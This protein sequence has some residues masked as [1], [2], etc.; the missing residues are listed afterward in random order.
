MRAGAS[1]TRLLKVGATTAVM[2]FFVWQFA[3]TVVT[4]HQGEL[5][6]RLAVQVATLDDWEVKVPLRQMAQLGE[7]A[8]EP[9][10]AVAASRRA[11]GSAIA[12]QIVD[13]KLAVWQLLAKESPTNPLGSAPSFLTAALAKHIDE[14]GPA[15][16]QWAEH[17]ALELIDLAD[18]MPAEQVGLLLADCT[19]ILVAVPPRGPKM[20]TV[21]GAVGPTKTVPGLDAPQP[22]L[23]TLAQASEM[24]WRAKV[25][26]R[27]KRAL[28]FRGQTGLVST[29]SPSLSP[30]LKG[31]APAPTT[32][33]WSAD[34][35]SQEKHLGTLVPSSVG[36]SL[37]GGRQLLQTS[38]SKVVDVPNPQAM[39]NLAS[40]LRRLSS[41]VLLQR[42]HRSD[43]YEAGIIRV[44]LRER[45]F[46]N[47][48]L[49][50]I[51][52]LASPNVVD[53]LRIFEVIS[54]LPAASGRRLL[55]GLLKDQDADVRLRALTA[56]ATTN[57][58]GLGDLARELAVGDEDLRVSELASRILRQ[59]R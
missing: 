16:K 47:G 41:E 36:A 20:R 12:R 13:E 31:A 43:F 18:A 17:L 39:Q 10:V 50:L 32:L 52:Q 42:L 23:E 7:P 26:S 49:L 34:S 14:F 40:D 44:V 2:L 22:K 54:T 37:A 58:P 59:V 4:W 51:Q 25:Q 24:D 28:E 5:A 30:S 57:D 9:L 27:A 19:R 3:P 1:T 11:L 46:A 8:L 6:R 56:I 15:G 33:R 21:V 48:E 35:G 53:R 55:R 45:G 29:L 38:A